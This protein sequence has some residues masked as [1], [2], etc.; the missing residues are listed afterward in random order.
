MSKKKKKK[1]TFYV[2]IFYLKLLIA[3]STSL[4]LGQGGGEGDQQFCTSFS[5]F[6]KNLKLTKNNPTLFAFLAI[7]GRHYS[8]GGVFK[9][10]IYF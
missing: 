5:F 9:L 7:K 1:F 4:V 2:L 3:V 10:N 6:I 8:A